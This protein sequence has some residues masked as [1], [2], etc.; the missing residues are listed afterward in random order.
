MRLDTF[1]FCSTGVCLFVSY[2]CLLNLQVD[3]PERITTS[4]W[5]PAPSFRSIFQDA[6]MFSVHQF[7]RGSCPV[8]VCAVQY[9]H[10]KIVEMLIKT[11]ADVNTRFSSNK[12]AL[13]QACYS[14]NQEICELLLKAGR[15]HHT[16]TQTH[17][18]THTA[19]RS[20]A[21]VYKCTHEYVYIHIDISTCMCKCVYRV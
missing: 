21:H 11:K 4:R 5:P 12:T 17:T 8:F 10:V 1:A 2:V 3:S 20:H 16:H 13:H 19:S 6:C 14:G 7:T 9:G 15:T 18:H